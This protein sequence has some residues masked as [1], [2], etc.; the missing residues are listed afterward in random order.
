MNHIPERH[1]QPSLED[2][3]RLKR[4][5]RPD[6]DFWKDFEHGL[7][8]KQLAAIVEPKPW[9]LG[10]SLLF[11]KIPAAGWGATAISAGAAAAFAIIAATSQTA[12]TSPDHLARQVSAPATSPAPAPLVAATL[13]VAVS[14]TPRQNADS[15]ADDTMANEPVRAASATLVAATEPAPAPTSSGEAATASVT[16]KPAA[17]PVNA[18]ILLASA[19]A[20]PVASGDSLTLQPTSSFLDQAEARLDRIAT[21]LLE[22][23]ASGFSTAPAMITGFA[24]APAPVTASAGDEL[25]APQAI[26][27]R[28]ARLLNAIAYEAEEK[29]LAQ[30][31]DRVVHRLSTGE[32]L[33]ASVTRLGVRGDRLSVSF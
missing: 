33:Y 11:G 18:T 14:T 21:P 3:L 15:I 12:S 19:D 23:V 26:S 2:L 25:D 5:E 29:D 8:Q 6:A 9:W 27:P 16:D 24:P 22:V 10:L 32:E 1:R 13:P 30:A 7:R 20:R 17:L 31:R 4:A 28:H